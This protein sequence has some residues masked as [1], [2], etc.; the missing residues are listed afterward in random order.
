VF[1]TAN[2]SYP[3][4]WKE[5]SF[6]FKLF[7]AYHLSMMGLFLVGGFAPIVV[8]VALVIGL[9]GAV[10]ALSIANRRRRNWRWPGASSRNALQAIV[11]LVLGIFFFAADT[12]SVSVWDPHVFAWFAGGGGFTLFFVLA[13]MNLVTLSEADFLI[14][15]GQHAVPPRKPA[16][17]VEAKWKTM[18]RA[19]FSIYFLI[20]WVTGVTYF[21]CFNI[22]FRDGSPAPTPSQTEALVDHGKTVYITPE[23]MRRLSLLRLSLFPGVT[24]V[25]IIGGFI[26]FGLGIKLVPN[27]PTLR[28]MAS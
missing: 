24:S 15:C 28:E 5:M 23:E 3:K 19:G 7:F 20:L 2:S 1:N 18:L 17:P 14:Q 10:S 16:Q 13:S 26:H 22:A 21:W 4:S 12:P 6:D 11:V 27:L 9:V 8:L 25:F